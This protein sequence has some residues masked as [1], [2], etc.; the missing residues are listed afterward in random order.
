MTADPHELA[1]L[2]WRCRRG[3]RE[4][5]RLLEAF[6]ERD[7][8]ALDADGR[9]RF[10]ALLELPDPRLAGYLL[11]RERPVDPADEALI[12]RIRDALAAGRGA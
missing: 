3:M 2:R 4:L 1:R 7:Y 9:V 8:A 12:A 11:G 10:D 5:D 6:V